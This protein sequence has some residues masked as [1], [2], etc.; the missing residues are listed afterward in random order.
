L[1][2]ARGLPAKARRIFYPYSSK[3]DAYLRR[4]ATLSPQSKRGL[5]L[6]QR[7]RRK[8]TARI[9]HTSAV[10]RG[11]FPQFTDRGTDP[12]SAVPRNPNIAANIDV[13]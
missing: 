13:G 7:P 9:C 4:T 12:R 11:A 10:K 2:A 1:L 5:G 3:Y 8:A 6:F